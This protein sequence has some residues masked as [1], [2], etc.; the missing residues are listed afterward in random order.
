MKIPW[1][2]AA[3]IDP[4]LYRS[5][6][7]IIELCN[8][9]NIQALETNWRF[10]EGRCEK[11]I[12]KLGDKFRKAGIELYSFH[13]PFTQDDDIACFYETNRR[14][15]VRRLKL[16]MEQSAL[17]G[18]RAV[19]LHPT[20]SHYNASIEGFDRYLSQMGKSLSQM[21]PLAEK[22][23]LII[24]LENMLPGAEGE[25]FG[26]KIEH[27]AVFKK[28][29]ACKNL[30]FCVDT[31]HAFISYGKKGPVKFFD[32]L[33]ESISIFHIQDNPGDRDLHIPPGRGLINWADVFKKMA[34]LRISFP[35]T[36]EATPFAHARGFRYS[37]NSWK[38]MFEEINAIAEKSF[39]FDGK[40]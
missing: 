17:F 40:A 33:K 18:N 28:E 15:S 19:V 39:N 2:W 3:C 26:A 14:E 1:K 5:M 25:R 6:D 30:G 16:I 23:N 37:K 9:A 12:V 38:K 36:I 32:L 13:L 11:E 29:F 35:A 21:V 27:F 7:E 4:G 22:L 24:C 10:T 8:Y 20:T 34:Q 31:G